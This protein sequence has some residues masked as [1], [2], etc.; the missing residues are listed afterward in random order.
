MLPPQAECQKPVC[1]E[2]SKALID[3]MDASAKPCEDFHQF[4]CGKDTG[5]SVLTEGLETIFFPR[6]QELLKDPPNSNQEQ[7]E[8]DF[9]Y[10]LQ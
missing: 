9:R 7:W 4:A 6:M 3:S 5:K 8:Q 2:F 10:K 1:Q